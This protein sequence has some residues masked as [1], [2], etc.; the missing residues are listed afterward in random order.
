MFDVVQVDA[1]STTQQVTREVTKEVH[2]HRAPTDESVALL[3][4]ME[5]AAESKLLESWVLTN[6]DFEAVWHVMEDC[7]DANKRVIIRFK[8]NGKE[9]DIDFRLE[10]HYNFEEMVEKVREKIV[11]FMAQQLMRDLYQNNRVTGYKGKWS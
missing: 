8:L 9:H 4:E 1:T 5:D 3:R 10:L 6:N 2:E 11:A 7:G